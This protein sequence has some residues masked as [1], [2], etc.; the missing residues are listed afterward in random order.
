MLCYGGTLSPYKLGICPLNDRSLGP[1]SR[2]ILTFLPS[3]LSYFL[4]DDHCFSFPPQ[5][6]IWMEPLPLRYILIGLSLD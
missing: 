3:P 2:K 5:S 4:V 6:I 1:L